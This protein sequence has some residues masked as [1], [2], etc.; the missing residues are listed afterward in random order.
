[1][2]PHTL[3]TESEEVLAMMGPII[4]LP[5]K[6]YGILNDVE[7]QLPYVKDPDRQEVQVSHGRYRSALYHP[8]RQYRERVYNGIYE[9]YA[10]NINSFESL[11]NGR[12]AS[13]I[14]LANIRKFPSAL[15]AALYENNISLDIFNNLIKTVQRNVKTLHR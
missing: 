1:M 14:A 7:L 12:V 9:G 3:S 6:L 2:K 4:A 11:Y 13:R 15:E 8:D 5:N 10:N